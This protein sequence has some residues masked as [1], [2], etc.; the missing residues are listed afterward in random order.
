MQVLI[1]W[2]HV[3]IPWSIM[4]HHVH[5]LWWPW[6]DHDLTMTWP[7]SSWMFMVCCWIIRC[8]Q[9]ETTA[10]SSPWVHWY[11]WSGRMSPKIEL[12]TCKLD[13]SRMTRHHKLMVGEVSGKV[14]AKPAK[15][16]R[17]I[18][19]QKT[20]MYTNIHKLY[21]ITT[22]FSTSYISAHWIRPSWKLD[23]PS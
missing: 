8:P 13:V 23:D 6:L 20:W 9:F 18:Y 3:F 12:S 19:P 17:H 4:I 21:L 15:Y 2:T 22:Q 16:A 11:H 14:Q 7:M 1:Q 10:E 5:C